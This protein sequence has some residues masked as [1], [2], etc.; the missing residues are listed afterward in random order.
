[1]KNIRINPNLNIKASLHCFI[2]AIWLHLLMAMKNELTQINIIKSSGE[3]EIYSPEKLRAGLRQTGIGN[4]EIE[5][6]VRAVEVR[7]YDGITARKVYQIAYSLLWK[8]SK[9]HAGR[10]RL[11]NAILDLGPSGYPF[12]IFV[13]RLFESFGYQV[14]IGELIQ[15]KCVQHEVDVVAFKPGEQVIVECKF[16]G[17]VKGKTNVQVPLYIHSRFMDIK[18]KWK[19]D[20]TKKD[21]N[22]RSFVATNTRFTLDAIQYAECVGLGLIS[23][24]YPKSGSLKYFIDRS[25]LHPLT[26]LR[27][28]KKADKQFFLNEGLVLC[29]ELEANENLMRKHGLNENQI[30]KVLMESKLLMAE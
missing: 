1:M 21:L 9:G 30:S 27:S 18:E 20:P 17:D 22:I 5:R 24:D 11:K 4:N 7:L 6:V 25:G 28:L 26:S 3:S 14:K 13:G 16:R 15:G 12:E 19:E 2:S 10:Y 29:R 23:W 8:E